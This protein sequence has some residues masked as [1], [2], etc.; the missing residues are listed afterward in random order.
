MFAKSS[1]R[2]VVVSGY[3]MMTPLGGTAVETFD[4]CAKGE[5]GIDY[6]SLFDTKGLPCRIGGEV[7]DPR[8]ET[9]EILNNCEFFKGSSRAIR[10]MVLAS[11]EA[12]IRAKLAEIENRDRIGVSM[13]TFGKSADLMDIAAFQEYYQEDGRWDFEGL[14][15]AGYDAFNIYHRKPDVA[16]AVISRIFACGGSNLSMGSACAAGTQAIGEAYRMIQ[17]GRCDVM[18]AGGCEASLGLTGLVGFTL[19]GAL[20][21]RRTA[22][23]K[24]SR[25]FDRK[26]DGFVLSE[27]AGAVVLEA[28][29][30]ARRRDA[31]IYGEI[32]GYGSSSDAYRITDTHPKGDGAV[33][34][35][36]KAIGEAG[37]TPNNIDYINAHG[38]ST[39][40][41]DYCETKAIKRLFK[42]R[43]YDIPVSSN[44]SMLG[45]GIAAAGPIEFILTLMG[46]ERSVILP[47]INQEF[48][49]PKCDLWYV[50]NRA[51]QRE[52][53]ISLCNSFAFGGQNACLCIGRWK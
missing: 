32:L 52:H 35:M 7:K 26:R 6:I 31:S 14:T 46:M 22:P 5:S 17:D 40:K 15:H 51:V 12:A 43:A 4:R 34:A 36:G 42:E 27:G 25:P 2:R 49:D 11:G 50:P 8:L 24:A 37:L 23:H 18:L 48:P 28:L 1:R 45:H 41:N 53:S 47:T 38:T 13:G 10:F 29:E 33:S 44:K 20:S 21:E 16:A 30:H 3:G 19:L 39:S 9:D